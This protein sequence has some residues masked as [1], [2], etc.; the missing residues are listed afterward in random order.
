MLFSSLIVSGVLTFG[1]IA[2]DGKLPKNPVKT[3][4]TTQTNANVAVMT[5][6]S[7]QVDIFLE[8]EVATTQDVMAYCSREVKNLESFK[9]RVGIEFLDKR[10]SEKLTWNCLEYDYRLK[11]DGNSIPS[12]ITGIYCFK[13]SEKSEDEFDLQLGHSQYPIP[14]LNLDQINE[15][16]LD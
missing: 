15:S 13:S 4:E 2:F 12:T 3:E 1:P 5:C 16:D 7:I 10:I 11:I 9:Q 14:F 6:S 8:K